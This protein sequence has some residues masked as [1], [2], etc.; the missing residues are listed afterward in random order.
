MRLGNTGTSHG[1]S[2]GPI[3]IDGKVAGVLSGGASAW[4][5]DYSW[6]ANVQHPDNLRF[7]KQLKADDWDIPSIP[8]NE[9]KD[10]H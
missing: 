2:G 5:Y 4:N 3:L 6:Y 1:D 9:W 7:L 8:T 10:P